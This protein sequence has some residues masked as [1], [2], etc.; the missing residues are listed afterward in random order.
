[1]VERWK[2]LRPVRSLSTVASGAFLFL[3]LITAVA[4]S[5]SNLGGGPTSPFTRTTGAAPAG[6]PAP[7]GE[8][9]PAV[10]APEGFKVAGPTAQPAPAAVDQRSIATAVPTPPTIPGAAG[11]SVSGAPE[12]AELTSP[13]VQTAGEAELATRDA[14]RRAFGESAPPSPLLWLGL[15]LAMAIAAGIAHWRLRA[16]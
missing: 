3:F 9:A 13:A 15:A 4:Q 1:V 8:Q 14:E 11:A 5:G 16:A 10:P 6:A 2:W 7:A 12:R